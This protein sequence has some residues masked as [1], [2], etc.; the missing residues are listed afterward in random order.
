MMDTSMR[1]ISRQTYTTTHT[2]HTTHTITT[3]SLTH[4]ATATTINPSPPPLLRAFA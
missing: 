3:H 1:V 2:T 4:I